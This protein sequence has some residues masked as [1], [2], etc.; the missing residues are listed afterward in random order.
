MYGMIHMVD[1]RDF[2]Q[3]VVCLFVRGRD[4]IIDNHC[5]NDLLVRGLYDAYTASIV[6][7]EFAEYIIEPLKAIKRQGQYEC[8]S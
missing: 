3:S 5:I 2:S 4:E 6:V 7:G 1:V 8:E